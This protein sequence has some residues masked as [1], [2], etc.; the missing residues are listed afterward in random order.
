MIKLYNDGADYEGI[1][2]ASKNENIS[3]FT[4][5]PTLMKQAGV[6]DYEFFAKKII[7]HLK[8]YRPE[9]CLSLEVFADTEKEMYEQAK[10]VYSWS[11]GYNVYI[12]IPVMNT[13]GIPNY[14]LIKSL[15]S[16]NISLNVT[17]VFTVEQVQKIYDALDEF[18][19]SII[20]IFAGRIADAGIDPCVVVKNSVRIR[21]YSEPTKKV[22]FLWASPREV[23]NYKQADE[24]GCDIITMTPDLIKKLKGFGKDLNQFSLETCQMFYN[25]AI[26]SGFKI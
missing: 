4:T 23:Y 13:K 5:N 25:D 15:S 18:T 8:T 22:E 17:A 1:I 16:E 20:S 12:K 6:T 2:F 14:N 26:A 9:T 19:P 3:G 24:C 21:N 11:N 7:S 10:K